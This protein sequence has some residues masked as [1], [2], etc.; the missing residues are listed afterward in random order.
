MFN[1]SAHPCIRSIVSF[2]NRFSCFCSSICVCASSAEGSSTSSWLIRSSYVSRS[3]CHLWVSIS[4][5]A[6]A[7]RRV[8]MAASRLGR[9]F[10]GCLCKGN[11]NNDELRG[12]Q[13][14]RGG[15][16][17]RHCS[18]Y[19]FRRLLCRLCSVQLFLNFRHLSFKYCDLCYISGLKMRTKNSKQPSNLYI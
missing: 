7:S 9:S 4:Y 13:K 16:C 12:S 8:R 18:L 19:C 14:G 6:G 5:R 2:S 17:V 15:R 1:T 10:L 3:R 11:I